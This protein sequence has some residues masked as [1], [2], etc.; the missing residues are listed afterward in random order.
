MGRGGA[1]AVKREHLLPF[2]QWGSRLLGSPPPFYQDKLLPSWGEGGEVMELKRQ[3]IRELV[4]SAGLSASLQL[5]GGSA[6]RVETQRNFNTAELRGI[7]GPLCAKTDEG[8]WTRASGQGPAPQRMHIPSSHVNSSFVSP[9]D[10][11]L[12]WLKVSDPPAGAA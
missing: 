10:R 1:F 7:R 2:F 8:S 4:V 5:Q 3:V 9:K 11:K 6:G 12:I